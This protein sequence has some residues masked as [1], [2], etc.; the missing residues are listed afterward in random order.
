MDIIN[1]NV[2]DFHTIFR[3]LIIRKGVQ[4]NVYDLVFLL[5]DS[6]QVII[7]S[8]CSKELRIVLTMFKFDL[9]PL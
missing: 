8:K 3:E 9:I 5:S 2:H 7:L 4:I 1:V 6:I